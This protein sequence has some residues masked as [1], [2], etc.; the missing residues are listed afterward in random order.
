MQAQRW[1]PPTPSAQERHVGQWT[2][3]LGARFARKKANVASLSAA[4]AA[5]EW[6]P[7]TATPTPDAPENLRVGAR[8]FSGRSPAIYAGRLPTADGSLLS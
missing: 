5:S 4:S 3:F 2:R 1:C 8:R 6:D 7:L